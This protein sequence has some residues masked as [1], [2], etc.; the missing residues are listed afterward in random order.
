MGSGGLDFDCTAHNVDSAT[1]SFMRQSGSRKSRRNEQEQRAVVILIADN[2][3]DDDV[4]PTASP[5]G[6][7]NGN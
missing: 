5:H 2:D 3:D 7:E 6:T 4:I 1:S